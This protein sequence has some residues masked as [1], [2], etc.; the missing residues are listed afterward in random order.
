M[1]SELAHTRALIEQGIT[2]GLHPGAQL[3][4][5]LHGKVVADLALGESRP[6]VPMTPETVNL[7]MSSVKV[8]GAVAIAQLWERGLLDLDDR[9]SKFISEFAARGKEPITIRHVLTHT[10]GF[11]AVPDLQWNDSYEDA[12]ARVCEAPLEPRWVPGITAGYHPNSGWYVLAELVRRIDGRRYENYVREEI[13]QPLGMSD[14]WVGMPRDLYRAYG[15]R[16]GYLYDT[17]DAPAA[18]P[19]SSGN[20]E[21]DAASV[22][23]GGNGR[24]PIRQLARLYEML[25]FKGRLPDAPRTLLP[26]TVEALTAR[27]RAGVHDLTFKHVMDWGLGLIVNSDHY[28][29]DTMPYSYGPHASPRAFGHS[30]HQS[31]CAFCDP[32]HGLVVSWLCNGMPGET[33]HDARQRAIN[34]AIYEDLRLNR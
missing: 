33:K 26:Q 13:L 3:Y 27:Q 21:E 9:V 18:K 19:A 8:I 31:S 30:G 28:A 11:R 25:Q 10:G 1:N 7:W 5:S 12:I 16:I 32:V 24:G 23:P 17:T 34:R 20:S 14:C 22:R 29:P 6:D 4:V 2:D 15:R